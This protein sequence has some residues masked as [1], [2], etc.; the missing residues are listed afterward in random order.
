MYYLALGHRQHAIDALQKALFISTDD[1]PA[2]VHLSRIYLTSSP[3]A[4]SSQ[5]RNPYI[6][7]SSTE[8]EPSNRPPS[9]TPGLHPPLP[10]K[11][12][13]EL[14]RSS[15]DLA[16]GLLS[17]LTRGRGWDVPEAWYFLA[18]AY[19]AQGRREKEQE[20]L[21]AALGLDEGRGVRE[22][23]GVLGWCI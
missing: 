10:L 5:N 9:P 17:H 16:A 14:D 8:E 21:K 13:D 19:G 4:F 23:Q 11:D 6:P 22:I 18:K 15:V 2:T 7:H 3:T 1:V 20:T 12:G